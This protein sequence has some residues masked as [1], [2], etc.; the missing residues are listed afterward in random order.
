MVWYGVFRKRSASR[1]IRNR[2][3]QKVTYDTNVE[4]EREPIAIYFES[5]YSGEFVK[6]GILGI[7]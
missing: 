5:I 2:R 1:Q 6:E 4:N 7:G 3:Q